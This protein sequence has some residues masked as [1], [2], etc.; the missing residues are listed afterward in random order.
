MWNKRIK[1]ILPNKNSFTL[2]ELLIVIAIIAIL[3]AMLL[4]ALSQAREKARQVVC[5]NNMKQLYFL[6]HLYSQDNDGWMCPGSY[7]GQSIQWDG[8]LKRA[9]YLKY[10][11]YNDWRFGFGGKNEPVQCPKWAS[12]IYKSGSV[13][14][15]YCVNG[16]QFF[17]ARDPW[18]FS[19]GYGFRKFDDVKRPSVHFMVCDG[20]TISGYGYGI[21]SRY[22]NSAPMTEW[23]DT[24]AT[25]F[26]GNYL[27]RHSNGINLL[28]FDGHVSY[29]TGPLPGQAGQYFRENAVLPW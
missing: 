19:F 21:A 23:F 28:Y 10:D 12:R 29:W 26:M 16:S 27:D 20:S 5:M 17:R 8:I 7:Q 4:P 6:F 25:P 18:D 3:S 2:I 13:K 22:N 14:Y 11:I 9:G 1:E 15:S 24:T